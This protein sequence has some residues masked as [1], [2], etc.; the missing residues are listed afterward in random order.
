MASSLG[1]EMYMRCFLKLRANS[2]LNSLS[3][4]SRFIITILEKLYE[5]LPISRNVLV[6]TGTCFQLNSFCFS[7][8]SFLK[9]PYTAA[10]KG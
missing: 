4:P 10:N 8:V 3:Y 1:K 7:S 2:R 9:F 6:S 5:F